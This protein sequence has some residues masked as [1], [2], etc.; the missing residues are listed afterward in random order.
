MENFSV[1]WFDAFCI[2]MLGVGMFVGKKRGM[3]NELLDVFSWLLMMVVSA[4]YYK[5]LAQIIANFAHFSLYWSNIICYLGIAIGIKSVFV[6]IKRA[7]GEKLI[8]SDIFGRAEFY[9]GAVGGA[10]R[11]ACMIIMI[12]AILHGRYVTKAIVQAQTKK[13]EQEY[14]SVF[15]PTYAKIQTDVLFD[16]ITGV[17]IREKLEEQMIESTDPDFF[18]GGKSVRGEKQREK[19]A[20]DK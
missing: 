13:I 19:P 2:I 16:S 9:F 20:W 15:F 7:V 14:G 18:P 10:V 6:Y 17:F 1:T 12:V 8:G 4:L 5:P 11:F 3:S